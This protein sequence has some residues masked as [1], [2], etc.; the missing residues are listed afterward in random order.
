MRHIRTLSFACVVVS[1][2]TLTTGTASAQEV[3]LK[4]EDQIVFHGRLVVPAGQEVGAAV[5]FDGPATIDGTVRN[6]LV[7]FNGDV[8]IS[9]TV[10]DDVV[11]FNGDVL[12][13]S[14]A[15]VGGNLV[16]REA[17][18][19]EPG[20]T[21][22][23]SQTRITGRLDVGEIGIASR[24]AWW[25]GYSMSTLILGLAL[26]ALGPALDGAITRVLRMQLG[27]SIGFGV[28]FFFLLPIAAV[29]LLITV[30][31]IPLGVFLLL[32]LALVYTVGYVVGTHGIG[33]L[34][35]KPPKSRFAAFAI[36]WLIVRA[37]GLIPVL[38]GLAWL[39]VILARRR[40]AAD[41]ADA[42]VGPEPG[43]QSSAI[44]ER[45]SISASIGRVRNRGC[46]RGWSRTTR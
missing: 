43:G 13:R 12:L 42:G 26:L 10:G 27:A 24:F 35:M 1:A 22:A 30:V 21:V 11:V 4:D 40:A 39:V 17:P 3:D 32:G 5:I 33:R 18:R 23:G 36:G 16:S 46:R 9:G 6:A 37:V 20:A 45:V 41:P 2:I 15:S 44:S 38:G 8:E 28:A 19:I 34:V 31:G 7:V 25:F 29:V 14:G